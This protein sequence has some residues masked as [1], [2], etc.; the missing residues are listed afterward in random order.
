MTDRPTVHIVHCIDTEGPLYESL[1]ATFERLREIFGLELEPTQENLIR[2]QR[3]EIDLGGREDSV[4]R[5]LAPELLNYNSTWDQVDRMLDSAMSPEFRNRL[6]DSFG[7]GWIYN[8][9]C[10]DHVGYTANP[11]RRDMGF[12]NVFD[13]YRDT[14]RRTRSPQDGIH[15]HH[16]PL[17]F[18]REG[19]RSATHY[20]AHTPMIFEIL[21]RRIIERKWFPC[22]NRPGFHTTRPDSHWL[23][24]QYIPFDYASQATAADDSTQKDV[25]GGRFGDWRRAPQTW[26][27]YHPDVDD[28]QVEG[29]CRRW[30]ARCLN[31][32]GRVRALTDKDVEDAFREAQSGRPA[33]LSFTDHDF[34]DLRPDVDLARSM[35]SR[36]AAK[37]PNVAF[38]FCEGRDALRRALGIAA[39]PPVRFAMSIDDGRLAIEADAPIFGPQPFLAIRTRSGQY[40]H[41]NLD[42]QTPFR[43][44]SYS[45]DDNT[46]P[47]DALESI[48]VGACD[49]TGNVTVSVLDG[50]TGKLHTT[51]H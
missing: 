35:I 19:H 49:A 3:R 46:V 23:M 5:V 22:V 10:I 30:I 33:V 6:T 14:L 26:T 2:L 43:S 25:A 16:H 20:F 48:G 13:H 4:A 28:Y 24:E 18:T 15:F 7:G 51:H 32:A 27:P 29:G 1:S 47:L 17:S 40:H 8:W 50:R 36:A 9:H 39:R 21:A 34:R 11:R 38:R 12:H 31:I 42:F 41:D 45:F 37:Y 44:W